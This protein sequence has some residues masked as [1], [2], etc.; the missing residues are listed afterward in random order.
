MPPRA[1][2]PLPTTVPTLSFRGP[3]ERTG[4]YRY[5]SVPARVSRAFAP[6]AVSGHIPVVGTLATLPFQSSFSPVGGGRHFVFV[7]AAARRATG[8]VDGATAALTLSPRPPGELTL[9]DDL[10]AALAAA[11]G[12]RAAF[13]AW[14]PSHRKQLLR[15][16][17]AAVTPPA[18]ARA[19]ARAVDHCLGR[20]APKT[21]AAPRARRKCPV[22]G[23]DEGPEHECDPGDLDAA[24]DQT[25]A[26]L[27]ALLAR[28]TEMVEDC[29]PVATK[30]F[31][32]GMVF[33]A[34]RRF[35]YVTPRRA[36]LELGLCAGRRIEHARFRRIETVTL[37]RYVHRLRLETAA[38][39][40]ATLAAWIWE[41]YQLGGG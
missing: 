12:A 24:F 18:R 36:W 8:L 39:L 40:D 2:P 9:P 23:G 20:A 14:P 31:E 3:V 32:R 41:A 1:K 7:N 17:D 29:G 37:D 26:P 5:V 33:V 11:D 21:P 34:E 10:V 13:D 35:L 38:D 22:C 25:P 15:V 27:M 28:L 19:V 30:A 6:W 16:L 4:S